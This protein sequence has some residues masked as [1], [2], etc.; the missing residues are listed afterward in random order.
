MFYAVFWSCLRAS[1][2]WQLRPTRKRPS[3]NMTKKANCYARPTIANGCFFPPDM[4]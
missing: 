4:A 3:R 1:P 2:R